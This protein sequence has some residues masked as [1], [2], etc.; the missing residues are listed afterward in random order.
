MATGWSRAELALLGE[1]PLFRGAGEETVRRAAEDSACRRED[2][3]RET[4]IYSP[5][6]F[7]RCLGVLLRGRARVTKGALVVSTLEA[8]ALFGA[9]ALFHRRERYESAITALRP[10]TAAFFPEEQVAALL[11]EDRTLSANYIR[12][13]S[14]RIHFL[15]RKVESLTAPGAVE[16][17]ASCLLESAGG[18]GTLSCPATELSR[19]L[20][21]SRASLYR[22]F[23]AL[24]EA[25][26]IRREGKTIVILDR[27]ALE[28]QN[29]GINP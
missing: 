29:G 18:S 28:N 11:S 17:L 27:R 15:S 22:A 12:Y 7:R 23:Q 19:R 13:L 16:K 2:F 3:P 26:A 20:D 8:G 25:G 24:E 10:C 4:V 5:E 9:A 14:E 21:L 1:T 6:S